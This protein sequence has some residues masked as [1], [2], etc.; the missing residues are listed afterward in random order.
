MSIL[1]RIVRRVKRNL[2]RKAEH[3]AI[4]TAEDK[5]TAT[6]KE[7]VNKCPECGAGVKDDARFCPECGGKIVHVCPDCGKESPLD[8]EYCS[9]C[10][11]KLER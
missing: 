1:S 10:G 8:K 9:H 4:D 6:V 2:I 3:E 5:I 7:V 11:T